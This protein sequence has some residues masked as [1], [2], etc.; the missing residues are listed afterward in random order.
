MNHT[1]HVI[2]SW[3]SYWQQFWNIRPNLGVVQ[4]IRLKIYPENLVEIMRG[5][6]K[7]QAKRIRRQ[8]KLEQHWE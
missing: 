4:N 2:N 5:I 3:M 8:R 1:F 6:V 7:C